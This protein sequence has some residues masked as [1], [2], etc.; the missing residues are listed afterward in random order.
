MH[1]DDNDFL[2]Q[3]DPN[4]FERPSFTVDLAIFTVRYEQLQILLV[5]RATPPFRGCWALPGGFIDIYQDQT[6]EDC[7]RRKLLEKTGVQAPYLEQLKTY[8]SRERDPRHWTATTVYF[9]LQAADNVNLSGNQEEVRWWPVR[10]ERVD[11]ILAFDHAQLL[12]DAISRLRAKLE[13]THIAVHLLPAEFTLPELQKTYEIILQ[14]PLDKSSFRRRVAHAELVEEVPG[15]LREQIGR[16]A[17][18]Y[19]FR[20]YARQTF[21]PRSLPR[22]A[23]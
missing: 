16:P 7:A 6:L 12:A 21:F 3:Y 20:H 9:A 10:G 15:K 22:N 4:A 23:K 14:Q 18:V 1:P 8:G 5:R 19:R 11:A 17:Q 13:Y 2:S